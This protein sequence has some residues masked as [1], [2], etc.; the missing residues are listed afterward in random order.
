MKIVIRNWDKY[1]PKKDQKTYTWLRLNNDIFSGQDFCEYNAQ[2]LFVWICIL[3]EASK[4]N[5]AEIELKLKYLKTITRL[6]ENNIN[7]ALLKLNHDNFIEI[8]EEFAPR[9]RAIAP[10]TDAIEN[11]PY[12]RTYERTNE[13]VVNC[14]QE[15]NKKKDKPTEIPLSVMIAEKWNSMAKENNLSCV[16]IPLAPD[17]LA[18]IRK[19]IQEFDSPED[20]DAIINQVPRSEFNLGK[21]DR[22]WKANFNWLFRVNKFNYRELF[23]SSKTQRSITEFNEDEANKYLTQEN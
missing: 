12:V 1:N 21:N 6:D 17:R 15:S 4:K 16:K 8:L 20:W 9:S 10:R 7:D 22:N 14:D 5:D 13:R 19:A 18:L 23:E 2:E 3:C 11:V